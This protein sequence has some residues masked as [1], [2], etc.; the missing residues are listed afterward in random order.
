M[1]SQKFDSRTSAEMLLVVIIGA[2]ILQ[3]IGPLGVKYGAKK[4]G[5]LGLNITEDDLIKTYTVADVMDT[6]VPVIDSGMPLSEVIKVVGGTDNPCYPVV[7]NDNKLAGLVTLNGIRST[8]ETQ[9]LNEWLIALDIAEPVSELLKPDMS[10]TDALGEAKK[11]DTEFLPVTA[12]GDADRYLGI[13]D[14]RAVYR[15]V[16]AEVLSKQKEADRMY[17]LARA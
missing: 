13:L 7:D 12:A 4:A 17:G 15:R 14:V 16:S 8:F 11:L 6:A 3:M 10:L 5:E 1:A 9:E 2:F